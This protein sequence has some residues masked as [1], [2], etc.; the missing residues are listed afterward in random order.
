MKFDK[1]L[2]GAGCCNGVEIVE[3]SNSSNWFLKHFIKNIT[4]SKNSN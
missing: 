1:I 3:K 2:L 4:I